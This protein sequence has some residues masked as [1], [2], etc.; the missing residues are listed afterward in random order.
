MITTKIGL[1]V[2]LAVSPFF[3]QADE[4][5][6]NR[7]IEEQI[8]NHRAGAKSQKKVTALA[9]Q[10][11]DLTAEYEIILRQIESL[12][13]YNTQLRKIIANQTDEMQSIRTQITEVKKTSKE[14]MPLMLEM[15]KNLKQFIALDIPFLM[16]ERTKR[17]AELKTIMDRAD[18]S[19]SEKYRRL[20]L[21]YQ[22]EA[23]YGRTLETY[24]GFKDIDGKTIKVN[25]LRVGRVALVYQSPDGKKQSYWD[26]NKK[27]WVKLSSRYKRAVENGIN[28]ALKQQP[29]ALITVPVPAPVKTKEAKP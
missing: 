8:K 6:L 1:T 3:L 2:L 4:G 24:R 20:L 5:K 9:E 7:V 13:S 29:P 17:L 12:R 10:T 27:A 26:K 25:Y 16:K 22:T 15:I 28:I 19:I 18:V 14:I 11:I 23:E 21:A